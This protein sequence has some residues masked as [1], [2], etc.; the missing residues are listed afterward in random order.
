MLTNNPIDGTLWISKFSF[1]SGKIDQKEDAVYKDAN[2]QNHWLIQA[3][4]QLRSQLY[5]GG[6]IFLQ[7]GHYFG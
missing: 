5:I 6:A 4:K 3:F 7:P 2:V 1:P